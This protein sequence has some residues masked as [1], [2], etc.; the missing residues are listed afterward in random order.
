VSL[1]VLNARSAVHKGALIGDI[2]QDNHLDVLAVSESWI[3]ESEP[4]AIKKDI[5]PPNYSV[6]HVHRSNKTKGGGLA[7]IHRSSIPAR[8]LKL[9]FNPTSFELQIVSLQV[10]KFLVKIVNVY[11]PL[12]NSKV[13]FLESL[14]TC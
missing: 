12:G 13:T 9:G 8:P 6:L 10:S 3:R 7:L 1:G 2:I 11:R 5:A 14:V 4:D